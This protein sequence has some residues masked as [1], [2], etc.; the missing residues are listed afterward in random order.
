M[1]EMTRYVQKPV[2]VDAI[3]FTNDRVLFNFEAVQIWA[4]FRTVDGHRSAVFVPAGSYVMW[5]DSVGAEAEIYDQHHGAW[6]PVRAGDWLIRRSTG[7]FQVLGDDQFRNTHDIK[8][9][10]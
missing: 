1:A 2:E 10:V 6:R 3:Q 8:E 4:G 5:D 7:G 9:D